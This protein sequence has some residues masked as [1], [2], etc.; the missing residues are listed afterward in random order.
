MRI[1]FRSTAVVLVI[2][3]VALLLTGC[4][5]TPPVIT[6]EPSPSSSPVFAS[7]EDALAAATEA[8]RKYLEVSDQIFIDGG[9]QPD[10]LKSVVDGETVGVRAGRVLR[11]AVA[12]GYRS[13]GGTNLRQC[14]S[15]AVFADESR[16]GVGSCDGVYLC[17]DVSAV[18]VYDA[19]HTSV[20]SEIDQTESLRGH[21][22]CLT[23][24]EQHNLLVSNGSSHGRATH[25][26]LETFS[27]ASRWADDCGSAPRRGQR[28]PGR[29][30]HRRSPKRQ[31]ANC[32]SA[33]VE[34]NA[35]HDGV[36]LQGRTNLPGSSNSG[37]KCGQQQRYVQGA[38][39]WRAGTGGSCSD[40]TAVQGREPRLLQLQ[41]GDHGRRPGQLQAGA[42][43]GRDGTRRLDGRRP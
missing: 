37:R 33:D 27:S 10:R 13:T 30:Q 20:V 39:G 26:E 12:R 42:R 3:V 17:E 19:M 31:V 25:V 14:R 5:P 32:P 11:H 28:H 21:V 2:G 24:A 23:E 9:S 29:L 4:A 22:R 40:G 34:A 1:P 35:G 43:H 18:D 7:D 16:D 8:Y 6:P 38:P 36:T 15:G 41:C